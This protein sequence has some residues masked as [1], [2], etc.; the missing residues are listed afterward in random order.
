M[1]LKDI[2]LE[3]KFRDFNKVKHY[4]RQKMPHASDEAI[5]DALKSL[6]HDIYQVGADPREHYYH[7]IFTPFHGGYQI[8]LLQQAKGADP[9]YYLV[10]INVNTKY[11]YAYPLRGKDENS[12][13]AGLSKFVSDAGQVVHVSADQES[14]WAGNKVTKWLEDH[15]IKSRLIVDEQ[16]SALGVIDRFI[17]TLRDMSDKDD[18]KNISPSEMEHLLQLYNNSVHSTT[19]M[20]PAEMN[21]DRNAEKRYIFEKIYEQERREKISDYDL[22]IGKHVRFMMPRK[23]FGKRRYQESK[24][25]SKAT[26]PMDQSSS[27]DDNSRSET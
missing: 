2:I 11:A 3:S 1:S 16:H 20:S 8:D 23:A 25:D 27:G 14:A 6:P 22:E 18:K 10:A 7:P 24:F 17:R 4:V 5:R 12:V 19:K 26:K 15:G 21:K 13:E 9:P